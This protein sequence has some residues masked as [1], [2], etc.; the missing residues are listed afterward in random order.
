MEQENN[1]CPVTR[2]QGRDLSISNG[3]S[4]SHHR[5]AHRRAGGLDLYDL[6][7]TAYRSSALVSGQHAITRVDADMQRN[8]AALNAALINHLSPVIIVNNDAKGGEY[9]LL[10]NGERKT[11]HPIPVVFEL[12][13]S[14]AHIPLGIF[15]IIAPYLRGSG[16][17]KATGTTSR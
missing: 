16:R 3:L 17:F 6:D 5:R 11:L 8:Y 2:H 14:I 12:A 9:T 10:F 7:M 13:K 4:R 15:S 1:A